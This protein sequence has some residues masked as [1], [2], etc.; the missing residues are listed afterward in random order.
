MS[1]KNLSRSLGLAF[2]LEVACSPIGIDRG[3]QNSYLVPEN[4]TQVIARPGFCDEVGVL[5]GFNDP[6]PIIFGKGGAQI[7]DLVCIEDGR[8]IRSIGTLLED[9]SPKGVLDTSDLYNTPNGKTLS[10]KE[11]PYSKNLHVRRI[12]F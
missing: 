5:Y 6:F 9:K 7:G 3:A 2:L 4:S 1:L 11:I 8:S 10:L 12:N